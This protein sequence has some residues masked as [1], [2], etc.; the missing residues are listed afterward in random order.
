MPLMVEVMGKSTYYHLTI[1]GYE[2]NN[3]FRFSFF[4]TKDAP[5]ISSSGYYL[6]IGTVPNTFMIGYSAYL[7]KLFVCEW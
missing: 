6:G 4:L 5:T 2:A 1:Y 3:V 7:G